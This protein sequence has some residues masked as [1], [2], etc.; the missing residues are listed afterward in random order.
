MSTFSSPN[1]IAK[2]YTICKRGRVRGYKI[3]LVHLKNYVWSKK[4]CLCVCVKNLKRGGGG[5]LLFMCIDRFY[6]SKYSFIQQQKL[7]DHSPSW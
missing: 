1:S 6:K 4:L 3:M 2:K 5:N 7:M